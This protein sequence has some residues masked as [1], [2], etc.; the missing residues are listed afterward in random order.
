MSNSQEKA[1]AV[2]LDSGR[3]VQIILSDGEYT[4]PLASKMQAIE[5]VNDSQLEGKLGMFE[6]MALRSQINAAENL[7]QGNSQHA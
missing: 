3:L 7:P 5:A 2:F 1:H 4:P 6:A